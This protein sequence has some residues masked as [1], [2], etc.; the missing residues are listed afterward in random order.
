MTRK[1]RLCFSQAPLSFSPCLSFPPSLSCSP[2]SFHSLRLPCD[3]TICISSWHIFLVA[4][5]LLSPS[6]RLLPTLF[7]SPVSLSLSL[8]LLF[9]SFF[10][11]KLQAIRKAHPNIICHKTGKVFS[12]SSTFF[13]CVPQICVNI[14][15]HYAPACSLSYSLSLCLPA[16]LSL[17]SL[18]EICCRYSSC[19]CCWLL[20]FVAATTRAR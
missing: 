1:L 2:S 19:C 16:C 5:P 3:F 17:T 6:M 13:A 14:A 12:S 8:F 4:F 9:A 7:L 20:L 10:C 18:Y 11:H 15:P